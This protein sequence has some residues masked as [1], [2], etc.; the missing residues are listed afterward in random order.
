MSLHGLIAE[1]TVPHATNSIL[2]SINLEINLIEKISSAR[3][4]GTSKSESR[5][6]NSDW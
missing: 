2:K 1:P 4:V 3:T 6:I 5:Q